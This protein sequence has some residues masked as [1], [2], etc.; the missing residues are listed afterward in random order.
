MGT[1]FDSGLTLDYVYENRRATTSLGRL[2]DRNYF[3]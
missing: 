3:E 2:I 1:G